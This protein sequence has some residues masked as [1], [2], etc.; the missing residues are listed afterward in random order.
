MTTRSMKPLGAREAGARAG[1]DNAM[2]IAVMNPGRQSLTAKELRISLANP[3]ARIEPIRRDGVRSEI[4]DWTV[5]GLPLPVGGR[6]TLLIDVLIDDFHSV[7]LERE[8]VLPT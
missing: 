3:Q 8:V 7:K 5:S 4:G 6:W 2:T 1:R